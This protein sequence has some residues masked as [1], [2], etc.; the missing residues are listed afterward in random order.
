MIIMAMN[1]VLSCLRDLRRDAKVPQGLAGQHTPLGAHTALL[2]P[3]PEPDEQQSGGQQQLPYSTAAVA[4]FKS[5]SSSRQWKRCME[6][7]LTDLQI[8]E[9]MM[10]PVGKQRWKDRNKQE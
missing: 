10:F 1:R 4:M 7:L 9:S 2:S 8:S 5:S 3:T 6:G